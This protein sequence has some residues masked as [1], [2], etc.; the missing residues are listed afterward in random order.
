MVELVPMSEDAFEEYLAY[1]VPHYA[2]ELVRAGNAHPDDG[3]TSAEAQFES[4]LSDGLATP[5]HTLYTIEADGVEGP[6][7]YL[8]A[9]MRE[10]GQKHFTALYD[11][12][13]L[14]PYRR[15]GYGAEALRALEEVVRGLGR[16]EIRLH[17][18]GHNAPARALYQKM[19]YVETNVNMAKRLQG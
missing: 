17:V 19:G 3:Q 5:G 1:A 13:I 4:L 6:V 18:F 7:G 10:Q 14:A 2:D 9:G 15:R 12:A 16:D 8:W 11:F